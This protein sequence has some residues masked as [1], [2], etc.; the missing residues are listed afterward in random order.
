MTTPAAILPPHRGWRLE[1]A[2]AG[3]LV[4]GYAHEPDSEHEL[5]FGVVGPTVEAVMRRLR[6]F[7]DEEEVGRREV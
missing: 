4:Q 2:Y 5:R 7:V 1:L 3:D 6:E